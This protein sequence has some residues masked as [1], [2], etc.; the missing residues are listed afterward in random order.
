MA[1]ISRIHPEKGSED[2][3]PPPS[4]AESI[5]ERVAESENVVGL[6]SER[7]QRKEDDNKRKVLAEYIEKASCGIDKKPRWCVYGEHFDG[8]KGVLYW[9]DPKVDPD[10]PNDKFSGEIMSE[11]INELGGN[12][13]VEM[14]EWNPNIEG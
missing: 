12:T 9:I 3:P 13:R 2:I 6:D 1:E 14:T 10:V 4:T 5:E 8:S 7:R 11:L